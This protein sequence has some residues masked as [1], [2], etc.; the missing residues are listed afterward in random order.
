MWGVDDLPKTDSS[1]L[2]ILL[3][4]I[5]QM[6]WIRQLNN[7]RLWWK[8]STVKNAPNYV[9]TIVQGDLFY[10]PGLH[11]VLCCVVALLLPGGAMRWQMRYVGLDILGIF[12][13]K[14]IF[15]IQKQS[16]LNLGPVAQLILCLVAK[17]TS[18]QNTS[19]VVGSRSRI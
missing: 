19:Q 3:R 13:E 12:F 10:S 6:S 18:V 1:N 11:Q 9:H 15:G 4:S 2:P 7:R 17:V 8:E 16:R 5:F 14:F